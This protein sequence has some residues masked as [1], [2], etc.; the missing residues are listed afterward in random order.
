MILKKQ[1]DKILCVQAVRFGKNAKT[2]KEGQFYISKFGA[3]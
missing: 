1:I 2:E 3:T